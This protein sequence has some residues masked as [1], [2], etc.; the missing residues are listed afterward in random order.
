MAELTPEQR[1]ALWKAGKLDVDGHNQKQQAQED[2]P[3][4]PQVLAEQKARQDR[5]DQKMREA[6]EYVQ[7]R[8]QEGTLKWSD[9]PGAYGDQN[10]IDGVQ[11]GPRGGRYRINSNGRKSYDVP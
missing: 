11:T 1:A 7:K 6:E 10:Q 8:K 5:I 4:D 2:K 3:A 9:K